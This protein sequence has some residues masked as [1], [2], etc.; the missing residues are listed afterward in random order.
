[1]SV[2]VYLILDPDDQNLCRDIRIVMGSVGRQPLRS[3]RGEDLLKG[4]AI[5]DKRPSLKKRHGYLQKTR[6][7][8]RISTGLRNTNEELVH[9]LVTRR[10]SKKLPPAPEHVDNLRPD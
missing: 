10:T 9:V 2:A 3:K 5:T 8:L 7:Q 4:Q 1:M 6:S